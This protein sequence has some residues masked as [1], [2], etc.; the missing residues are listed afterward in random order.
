MELFINNDQHST[1]RLG[2]VP[3]NDSAPFLLAQEFDLFRKYGLNVHLSRELGWA[4]IRDKVATGELT[5]A[6][7]IAGLPWS[8]WNPSAGSR[9]QIMPAPLITSLQGNAITISK[10]YQDEGCQTPRA[11]L[12][13]HMHR[14]TSRPLTFAVVSKF[15]SHHILMRQW[16]RTGGIHPDTEANLVVLPPPQMVH[17]LKAGH[18][19]GYC[20]GEPWNSIGIMA[21]CGFCAATSVEISPYHPEKVLMLSP[22]LVVS[23]PERCRQL[24]AA[25]LEACQLCNEPQNL[26]I[27]GKILSRNDYLNLS[28]DILMHSLRGD[29]LRRNNTTLDGTREFIIF[30]GDNVNI[31]DPRKQAWIIQGLKESGALDPRPDPSQPPMDQVFR[32][33]IFHAAE[34][35]LDQAP[36]KN[37]KQGTALC[38]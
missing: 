10:R 33:D 14:K 13:H 3:L 16:L 12:K 1:I 6:Q 27:I 19:D 11:M 37:L 24:I 30:S 4:S 23:N 20:V 9:T 5:A 32:Q 7:A 22:S 8:T 28:P 29:I 15:S 36:A 26:E 21:G 18:I 2:F 25:L 34:Q 35:L 17:H 38:S 31:P